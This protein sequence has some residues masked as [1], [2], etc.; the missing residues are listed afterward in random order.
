MQEIKFEEPTKTII[1]IADTHNIKVASD[2]IHYA[3]K[4][5]VDLFIHAGDSELPPEELKE[6]IAVRGNADEKSILPLEVIFS[7]GNYRVLVSHGH[8]FIDPYTTKEDIAEYAKSKGCNVI[9]YGHT[10][11][12]IDDVVDG[13]RLLNPGAIESRASTYMEICISKNDIFV[14]PKSYFDLM[15]KHMHPAKEKA[16]EIPA[17]KPAEIPAVK[18]AEDDF[19]IGDFIVA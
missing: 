16:E 17:V 8:L 5:N 9:I 3:Y 11:R 1:A 7:V 18:Y 14:F 15:E 2:N 19:V 4:N 13:V 10:H 12:Y 6:Y